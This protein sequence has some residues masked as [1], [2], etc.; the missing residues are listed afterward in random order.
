MLPSLSLSEWSLNYQPPAPPVSPR[1]NLS[2]SCGSVAT[3]AAGGGGR[4]RV[5]RQVPALG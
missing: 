1:S 2:V 3:A 5:P 4:G